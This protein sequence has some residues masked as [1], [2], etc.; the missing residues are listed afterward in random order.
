VRGLLKIM[1]INKIHL[2]DYLE[3][4]KGLTKIDMILCDP[5]YLYE[6]GGNSKIFKGEALHRES[7]TMLNSEFG[8][9]KIFEFLNTTKTLM[10][11]PQWYLFCSEKQLGFYLDWANKNKFLFNVLV[12][13]KPLSILN[14]NRYSTNL[15]YIVRIYNWGVPL[16]DLEQ[17]KNK[18]YSKCK[19]YNS[20][21]GNDK[22]HP[23]QKPIDLLKEIIEISTK[24]GDLILDTFMGSGSTAI[25][26]KETNRN[27][28][29]FEIDNDNYNKATKRINEWKPNLLLF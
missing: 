15:E 5:P 2:G 20:I 8:E 19:V 10:E 28:I 3:L 17:S 7:R 21:R 22:L 24:E 13:S 6:K 23:Q 27:F 1:E 12:W 4:V 11:K 18:Y 26:C 25:A 29:G 16:N 9:E 14:R